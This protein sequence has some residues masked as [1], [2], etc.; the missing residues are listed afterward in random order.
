VPGR[1]RLLLAEREEITLGVPAGDSYVVIAARL[2]RAVTTVSR[3][4]AVNGGRGGCRAWRAHE[5]AFERARRPKSGRLDD[6]ALVGG[7]LAEWWPPVQIAQRL[8]IE[9]PAIP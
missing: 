6:P 7:W 4:V 3:E 9:Y 8:R 1:E 5:R 2:G